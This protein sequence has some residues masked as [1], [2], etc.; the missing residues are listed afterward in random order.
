EKSSFGDFS[1]NDLT[2]EESHALKLANL[3]LIAFVVILIIALIPQNSFLRNPETGSLVAGSA[4]MDGIIPLIML[5]FFIPAV[6][7]GKIAKTFT[8]HRQVCAAMGNS[9]A[10]MSGYIALVFV[11][12]QFI[13]YFKF[14]NIGTVIALKGATFF[15]EANLFMGSASAKWTFLAPV[16][17]PMFML[18]GFSPELTQVAYRIGDSCTNVITPLMSQFATIVIFTKR[19]DEKAG[20]GTLISMMLPYTII[21]LIGW[22]LLLVAWMM[23]GLPVGPGAPLYY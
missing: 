3:A 4:F 23:T 21:F 7:Y 11:S 19:Y 16:F 12:A 5:F 13:N 14:T 22:S 1:A 15:R 18:L 20:I 6:V 2:T 10:T 8:S 9:M 17:I